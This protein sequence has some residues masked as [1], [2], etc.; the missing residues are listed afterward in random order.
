MILQIAA[1]RVTTLALVHFR[2][3]RIIQL[4]SAAVL[5]L[6]VALPTAAG[7]S[8][9]APAV[10]VLAFKLRVPGHSGLHI[11]PAI[12]TGPTRRRRVKVTYI[13]TVNQTSEMRTKWVV[14]TVNSK[15]EWVVVSGGLE[16]EVLS[17]TPPRK[18]GVVARGLLPPASVP[19]G[20]ISLQ[21]SFA[22]VAVD[23]HVWVL[24]SSAP[25]APL[26]AISP[27]GHV[28]RTA[29]LTGDLTDMTAGPDNT[30]DVSDSSG[31]LDRCAINTRPHASCKV[32][33]VPARFDAGTADAI[34]QG[35]GRVW[36]TDDA[37]QLASF[38]PFRDRFA[39]PYGDLS[40]G[41]VV[42]GEASAD[43]GSIADVANGDLYVAAG[44]GSDPL[45]ENDL[46][47]AINPRNGARVAS[48]SR[49][50]TNVVALTAASDGN[51]WFVNERS[52]S[53]GAGT[54][55]VLNTL[56]GTLYQYKLPK[57]YRLPPSGVSIDP[58]PVGSN[59][60][61]F[62]L[63]TIA[64]AKAALGEVTGI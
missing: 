35:G 6:A 30:I 31:N 2:R 53:T 60:V 62:T 21:A 55:G 17:V 61:F 37:G 28:R 36:F 9:R 24:D 10:R 5:V 40:T 64:G 32:V 50:L 29:T 44:E 57:G 18:I 3:C 20:Q 43:P 1:F 54:V 51:I 23:G 39:G 19:S 22:S 13:A 63:Q 7:A 4:L 8:S 46:I 41:A 15:Q 25:L 33:R 56:H 48:F 38:N 42:T 49:G 11:T 52:A 59:T 27:S 45:F 34:G 16:A 12:T 14:Q 47:R 58:G 26:Y